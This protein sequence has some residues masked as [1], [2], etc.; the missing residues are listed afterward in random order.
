M[1]GNTKI[2]VG[3]AGAIPALVAM[4]VFDYLDRK[5]PEPRSLRW[6]VAI[7]GALSVVPVLMVDAFLIS[8]AAPYS[9]P[10][11]TYNGAL[12]Q[13]FAVAAAVEELFKISV[14]Y[15]IV[16]RR[17]EFDERMDGIVYGACCRPASCARC[18]RCRVTRCGAR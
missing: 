4:L 2:F 17:A 10:G 14:I 8:A 5:R 12:F 6:K 18:S 13:S 3:L 16:W 11:Y 1:D 7:G 9:Y 15:W